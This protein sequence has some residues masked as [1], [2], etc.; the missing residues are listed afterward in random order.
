MAEFNLLMERVSLDDPIGHMFVVDIEFDHQKAT[1]HQIMYNEVFPLIV[2][3]K[4]T[5]EANERSIFQL[6]ELYSEDIKGKPK[7]YKVTPKSQTTLLPKRCIPIYL[8][9]LKFVIVRCGWKVTKLYKHYYFEQKR[10]KRDFILTNQKARQE[11]KNSIESDFC[12]LLNNAN[13]G[14]DCRNNLD[15]CIFEPVNDEI[16]ELSFIRK[17][18]RNLFDKEL[19]PFINSR[20]LQEEITQKI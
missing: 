3:K 10:F 18:H 17:Y 9:E 15:N 5:L 2:D 20:I 14:Y 1:D 8:E 16:Q 6:V 4:A 19:A 11:A 13:F 7:N 12:K